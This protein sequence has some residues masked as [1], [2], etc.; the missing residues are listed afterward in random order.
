LSDAQ[1][2]DD[3]VQ[4]T[5]LRAWKYFDSFDP[6]T[7]CCAWLFRI[8]RNVWTDR[9]RK[10]R[11]EIHLNKSEAATI[12]AYYDWEGEFLKAESS[13]NISRALA[14]LPAE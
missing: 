5:D 10:S 13:E 3:L 11:L 9:W 4:E 6:T 2:A 7:N 8:L 1:T 14:E 12:E